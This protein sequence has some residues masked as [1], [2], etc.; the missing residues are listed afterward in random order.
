M[1]NFHLLSNVVRLVVIC[2]AECIGTTEISKCDDRFPVGAPAGR[3]VAWSRETS[4]ASQLSQPEKLPNVDIFKW[5]ADP[6]PLGNT[7]FC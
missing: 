4:S 5:V 3:A 1:G 6:E 7:L 2:G